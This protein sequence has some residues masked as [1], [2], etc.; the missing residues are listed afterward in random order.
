MANLQ[1]SFAIEGDVEL[2]R[3]L[4]GVSADLKNWKPEFAKTGRYLI[5]TFQQNFASAGVGLGSQWKPLKPKYRAWKMAHGYSGDILVKTGK[6]M[7]SFEYIATPYD[8]TIS[9]AMPYFVYHQSNK[10]RKV[11]PRRIMMKMT[12]KLRQGV[13]K[14]FQTAVQTTLKKRGLVK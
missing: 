14:I 4:E 3:S 11:L 1:L 2:N 7:K 10:P 9:N 6:M 8:V 13:V 5:K 12:F